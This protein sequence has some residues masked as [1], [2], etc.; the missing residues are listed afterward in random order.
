MDRGEWRLWRVMSQGYSPTWDPL[1]VID[2]EQ[3]GGEE[4]G[5]YYHTA[6]SRYEVVR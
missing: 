6:S 3:E 2:N 5:V 4:Q 1:W